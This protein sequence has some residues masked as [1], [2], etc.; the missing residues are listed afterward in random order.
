VGEGIV[1]VDVEEEDIHIVAAA[2]AAAAEHMPLRHNHGAEAAVAYPLN[3]AN[4]KLNKI[5]KPILKLT[6]I[7][8][9][10]QQLP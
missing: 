2:A 4:K 1:G 10:K 8:N 7:S 9:K 5:L 6:M 3:L